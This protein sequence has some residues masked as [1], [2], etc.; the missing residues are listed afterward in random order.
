MKKAPDVKQPWWPRLK[1]EVAKF[2]YTRR[3]Q[4]AKR[5]PAPP[6]PELD[7]MDVRWRRT[8]QDPAAIRRAESAAQQW[9]ER[10]PSPDQFRPV[11]ST[12]LRL[13]GKLEGVHILFGTN[14]GELQIRFTPE[15]TGELKVGFSST[16]GHDD[17]KARL[18]QAGRKMWDNEADRPARE[19]RAIADAAAAVAQ[20]NRENPS[21]LQSAD[22]AQLHYALSNL[23]NECLSKQQR[24]FN[25]AARLYQEYNNE[26]KSVQRFPIFDNPDESQQVCR[27]KELALGFAVRHQRP[28]TMKEL[29]QAMNWRVRR[30]KGIKEKGLKEFKGVLRRA[31]LAWLPTER[32]LHAANHSG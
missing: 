9:R 16:M 23:V 29:R 6:D 10:T 3:A 30:E 19:F 27:A 28:P 31:G 26:A 20:T 4:I 8:I 13:G 22:V 21:D 14:V 2:F 32:T 17:L 15:V 11:Y 12:L 7:A 1:L 18:N 25:L 24:R 5:V